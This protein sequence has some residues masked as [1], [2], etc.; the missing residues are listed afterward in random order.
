MKYAV[1]RTGGKQYRV[2]EGDIIE[3]DRLSGEANGK[4]IFEEVLLLS[5]DSGVKLGKPVLKENVE[6]KIIEQTKGDKIY[7][8]KYK[9]KVRYRRRTGFRSSLTKIQI[10]KIGNKKEVN[11][12]IEKNK[13]KKTASQKTQAEKGKAKEQ[14]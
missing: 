14:K 9:A 6:G 3:V 8:A 2:S 7:V 1:I 10:E 11:Q 4:V 13:L 5:D 12:P